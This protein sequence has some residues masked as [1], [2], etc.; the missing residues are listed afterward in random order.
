MRRN[1]NTY[2]KLKV[3]R[4]TD[5]RANPRVEYIKNLKQLVEVKKCIIPGFREWNEDFRV[6]S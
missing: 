6:K 4:T 3:I 5:A 2:L 1:I